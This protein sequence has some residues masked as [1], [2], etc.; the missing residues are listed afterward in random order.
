MWYAAKIRTRPTA[1]VQVPKVLED[2]GVA[3]EV[4]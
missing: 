4:S 2:K 3:L 1:K